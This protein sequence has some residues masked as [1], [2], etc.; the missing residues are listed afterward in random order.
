VCKAG[1]VR[2]T[3]YFNTLSVLN[4]VNLVNPVE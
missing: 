2:S 4:L 1:M 3:C